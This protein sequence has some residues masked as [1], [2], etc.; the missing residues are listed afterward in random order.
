[1]DPRF[2][3]REC[4]RHHAEGGGRRARQEE[5]A[6]REEGGGS[7]ACGVEG[8]RVVEEVA[9]EVEEEGRGRGWW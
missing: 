9:A 2:W 4:H 8:R 1:M 6:R 3:R 7:V 5:P